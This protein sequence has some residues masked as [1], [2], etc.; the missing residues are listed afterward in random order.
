MQSTTLYVL[1]LLAARQKQHCCIVESL[2]PLFV[3]WVCLRYK[4]ILTG[5]LFF[6]PFELVDF[7]TVLVHAILG[8]FLLKPLFAEMLAEVQLVFLRSRWGNRY[9]LPMLGM[10]A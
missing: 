4:G 8:H 6:I 2:D 1:R 10:N 3:G 5:D 9:G 7:P